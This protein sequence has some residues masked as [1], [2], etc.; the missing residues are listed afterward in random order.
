MAQISGLDDPY[1]GLIIV[2]IIVAIA[3]TYRLYAMR[4]PGVMRAKCPKCG[5]VFDSSRSFPGI[6]I[7]PLKQLT[8][9]A[10]GK[11]SLMNTYTKDAITWPPEEKKSEPKQMTPEE[12]E[13]KRIEDSKYERP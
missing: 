10:C 13:K 12:L 8:C 1:V 11:T 6:H 4:H 3:V 5:V 2:G 7:G 9:P